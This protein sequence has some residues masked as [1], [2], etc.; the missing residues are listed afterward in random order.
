MAAPDSSGWEPQARTREA[1]GCE[2]RGFFSLE[3][4]LALPGCPGLD[5]LRGRRLAV[6]ECGHEIP[7]DPC[8]TAC[9]TGAIAVGDDITALPVLDPERCDGCGTCQPVC[10]GLAIFLVDMTRGDGC[11]ELWLPHEFLPLP[12]KGET[13]LLRDRGGS[14]VGEGEVRRV[15][16]GARLD[17]T[18][19]VHV[20][21]PEDLA[22]VVRGIEVKR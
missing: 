18:T 5:D 21:V 6:V 11:A 20:L 2:A 19:I 1:R 3:E 16:H 8:Q 22:M 12:E 4:V 13:V 15:R 9:P 10:P 14:I 17:R 7:C